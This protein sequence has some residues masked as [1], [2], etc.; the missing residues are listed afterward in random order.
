[1]QAKLDAS[2]R[3][4]G[5]PPLPTR[6]K[7]PPPPP[8]DSH[9]TRFMSDDLRR[10]A[11]LLLGQITSNLTCSEP[12]HCHC[13][14]EVADSREFVSHPSSRLPTYP[15][16]APATDS[17]ST[18]DQEQPHQSTALLRVVMDHHLTTQAASGS[19]LHSAPLQ[20][21]QALPRQHTDGKL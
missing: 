18:H 6:G 7:L 12:S 2:K 4:A 14:C 5:N 15:Q 8:D 13:K 17:Y 1:M 3:R 21:S 19:P 10:N 16:A 11:L 9:E 20:L